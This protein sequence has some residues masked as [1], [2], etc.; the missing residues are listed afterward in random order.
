MC[1]GEIVVTSWL[2]HASSWEWC[3]LVSRSLGEL[4][5][6]GLYVWY[7]TFE[8]AMVTSGRTICSLD[9]AQQSGPQALDLRLPS[10]VMGAG[11]LILDGKWRPQV[12]TFAFCLTDGT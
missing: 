12:Q 5:D 6:D 3:C 11:C 9:A 7:S 1:T 10:R 2:L 4:V 8:E